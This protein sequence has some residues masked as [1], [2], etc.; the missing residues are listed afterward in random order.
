[1]RKD[2][3]VNNIF[4]EKLDVLVEGNEDADTVIIF[5][6]GFGTDKDE[7]ANSFLDLANEFKD[8]YLLVRFDQSG[9]GE[10]EGIDEEF[11]FQKAAGDLDFIIRYVRR[12]YQDKDVNI[13]A[14]SLGTFI[15]ALLSPNGIS[16]TV[17]T[18]AINL[19]LQLIADKLFDRIINA[20]GELNKNGTTV[21]PRSSGAI[22]KV[23]KDF[24]RV[25]E[26][27][28]LNVYLKEFAKK[29]DLIVFK[30]IQ[31]EV[32]GGGES[33]EDYKKIKDLKYV[34]ITGDHNFTK[35]G[36]RKNLIQKIKDFLPVVKIN[37]IDY[38]GKHYTYQDADIDI[39]NAYEY[40]IGTTTKKDILK[41][42]TAIKQH[43][44]ASNYYG[45]AS[46]RGNDN[47]LNIVFNNR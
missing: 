32:V 22:Q 6:H 7:G 34:E 8:K 9:Y 15:T 18:G 44:D 20:G 41:D 16:K 2:L 39:N 46:Y 14:H 26:S 40:V 4:G 10:S 27:N 31:D 11:Q 35:P 21:Y 47:D 24:W 12:I 33:F 5:V 19:D 3:K 29:T 25:L 1:M 45:I 37:I 23:G 36:D 42:D 28:E 30:S 43:I 38:K 17:F 13:I